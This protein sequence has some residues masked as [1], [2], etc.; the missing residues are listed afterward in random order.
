[1]SFDFL[2]SKAALILTGLLVLQ[3]V[4]LL[5]YNRPESLPPIKPLDSFPDK[6]ANWQLRV[7]GVIEKEIVET[8][9]ADDLMIRDYQIPG[10]A[11]VN[12]FVAAFRSQRN[13]KAPHSPKN[14]L[15][16]AGWVQ[17][18]STIE[19]LTLPD[20]HPLEVNRYVVAKGDSRSLVY[21][22]Y[23]S[24]DRAVANEYKAKY[25]VVEDAIRYNRTD[26]ALIRV[27]AGAGHSP[28]ELAAADR[29]AQ[30][31][32]VKTYPQLRNF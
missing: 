20:G 29:Y 11:N 12:L 27:V 21:Y 18:T 24:R 13:G 3:G 14:C 19:T 9:Q 6:I 7:R 32:I 26:T 2:K 5:S 31:F 1:M 22:W 23:Q 28:Q 4:V 25:Y 8:L 16:G 30:D 17:Q 10:E 15:P